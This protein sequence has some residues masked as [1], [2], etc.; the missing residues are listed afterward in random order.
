MITI[1]VID[2]DPDLLMSLCFLL[3]RKGFDVET[4]TQGNEIFSKI[5]SV[6]PHLIV[7]DVF[8][9]GS[10]GRQLCNTLKHDSFYKDIPVI[11]FSADHS[12]EDGF[13]E[14][15]ANYF[16]QKPFEIN[17]LIGRIQSLVPS[18]P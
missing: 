5:D 6:H 9:S 4:T 10:D 11:L 15:G 17:H 18:L 12:V 3:K 1:L 14:F 7:M 2:D 13:E 8:L 16:V